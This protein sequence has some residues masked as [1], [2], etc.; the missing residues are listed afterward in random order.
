MNSSKSRKTSIAFSRCVICTNTF[1]SKTFPSHTAASIRRQNG[2]SPLKFPSNVAED[3]TVPFV[4]DVHFLPKCS[5]K[6]LVYGN[7]SF[8]IGKRQKEVFR[9]CVLM[10]RRYHVKK[11]MK[12]SMSSCSISVSQRDV[13]AFSL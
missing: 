10:L 1:M 6:S 11:H 4:T 8:T 13:C 5:Q 7:V 12:V 2:F 3:N 9:K